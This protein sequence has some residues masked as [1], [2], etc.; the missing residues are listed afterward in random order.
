MTLKLNMNQVDGTL[1][2]RIITSM[3]V[4]NRCISEIEK[5]FKPEYF[6]NS[7]ARTVA[8]WCIKYF[9]VYKKA[10]LATINDIYE[11][12]KAFLKEDD[13]KV[14]FDL[15]QDI[16][17][18]YSPSSSFNSDYAIDQAYEYFDFQ[19]LRQTI[20]DAQALLERGDKS[21]AKLVLAEHNKVER[22]TSK[23][24]NPFCDEEVDK[25]FQKRDDVSEFF[26]LNGYLGEFMG[27]M[28]PKWLVGI[29]APFKRGK[30][31]FLIELMVN[32]IMQEK[33]TCLF[34]LEMGEEEIKDR[35][36]RRMLNAVETND[37]I[38]VK[39]DDD[40]AEFNIPVLDCLKNQLDSCNNPKRT[41]KGRIR[42][43]DGS[44]PEWAIHENHKP[45]T[46]CLYNNRKEFVAAHWWK[47]IQALTL[48][49]FLLKDRLK[50]LTKYYKNYCRIKTYPQHSASVVDFRRDLQLLDSSE[51]FKT[52]ILG[53]DYAEIIAASNRKAVGVDKEDMVWMEQAQLASE[54]NLLYFVPTQGN[55][56]SL[57]AEHLRQQH[58]SKWIGKLGHVTAMYCLNQ[59]DSEKKEHIMRI[60]CM[61]HRFKPF[62][63][64]QEA[65]LLQN[66]A[67]GQFNL[68]SAPISFKQIGKKIV[69]DDG[70]N[71]QL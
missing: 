16:S 20:R 25:F 54:M 44:L 56:D 3:I 71:E 31:N 70:K 24:I 2:K 64:S 32:A 13:A 41:S 18:K 37:K 22:I 57:E 9:S 69:Q 45:C 49:S 59:M 40:Y 11:N 17:D 27:N 68:A 48:D 34:S 8:E 60:S 51:G 42:L 7:F 29:T 23:W 52:E 21:R 47:P 63:M 43:K 6:Q 53:T 50:N 5:I 66:I 67:A 14:I 19:D 33:H 61:L 12:E 28:K 26:K 30:T 65:Y 1:E 39:K 35:L 58:T 36:Y 46:Y 4:S 10:P 62:E 15:L 55:K 38:I